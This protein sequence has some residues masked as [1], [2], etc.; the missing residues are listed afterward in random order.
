M[1]RER[2]ELMERFSRIFDDLIFFTQI[3]MEAAEDEEFL[4]AMKSAHIRGVLVGVES[5]T[6]AC[7]KGMHKGFNLS[8]EELVARLKRFR[9]F[10]GMMQV[11][12]P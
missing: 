12:A 11:I 9:R 10:A 6:D 7:L 2:I 1:R 5:I 3:T 8:G 4:R